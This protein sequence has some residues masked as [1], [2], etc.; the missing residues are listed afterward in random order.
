[1]KPRALR[2]HV[3]LSIDFAPAAKPGS[4]SI[5]L[6]PTHQNHSFVIPTGTALISP[7]TLVRDS[8]PNCFRTE[9]IALI[10]ETPRP[11]NG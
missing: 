9:R 8:E 1:M 5:R 11:C 10:Q 3:S 7:R 2:A 6:T 4:D